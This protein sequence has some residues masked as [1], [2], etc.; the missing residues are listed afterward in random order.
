MP[1]SVLRNME[2]LAPAGDPDSLAAALDAGADA[3]YLG[4]R[5]LNARRR[6]R[7]FTAD[8]LRAAV[9]TAHARGRRIYLALN[10]DISQRELGEAARILELAR[11]CGVDAVL[12]RD[13][14][15][16]ALRPLLGDLEFHFS[17]QTCMTSSADVAAA[18]QLGAARAVL[19]REL[20]LDEIRAAARA[21]GTGVEV[22]VQG[23]L[24]FCIS[25]RCLL[26][27]WV[28]GR[29]GNRGMCTSPCRVPW[30]AGGVDAGTPLS[31]LDL[32]A[33]GRL[34]DLRRAGVVALKIEGR[35]KNA[36]WVAR[37][38]S[39]YR[40]A[41]DS[42]DAAALEA[43]AQVL[44]RYTGRRM[45]CDYLDGRRDRLT[46]LAAGRSAPDGS[47][48]EADS[49]PHETPGYDF[50]MAITDRA[51]EC[52]CEHGGRSV[53]WTLPRTRVIRR[54]RA[55][56]AGELL[57]RLGPV[58]GV[59]PRR[60]SASD[61]S[62]LLVPRA[63]NAI[64]DR[65]CAAVRQML[66]QD[67][68]PLRI[69]LPA[70]VAAALTAPEPHPANSLAL[71][72]PPDRARLDAS[73][74]EAFMRSV[75]AGRGGPRGI[76]VEGADA[77]SLARIRSLCRSCDLVVALPA[78]FFEDDIPAVRDLLEACSRAGAI[79]EINSFGG[80][81]LARRTRV[82]MEGGPGM[83]VLNALA[84]RKLAEMGMECVTLCIEAD[85][86][87]L[88]ELSACCPCPCSVAVFGRPAL[89][90]TRAR[91]DEA[92]LGRP[93][94]DRRGNRIVPRLERDLWVF[95]PA[96]PFDLRNCANDRIRAAHLVVDLVGSPDP[97]AEW[98]RAPGAGEK[99]LRFN[100][101]RRLQ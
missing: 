96:D 6:A 48:Q 77:A 62:Y 86:R 55:V 42:A 51:I 47:E 21:G 3:V 80:W 76:I 8:E 25:G 91:L 94:E 98:R 13:A 17:T 101:D 78:V 66:R 74:L 49:A 12:V 16:L 4:L 38:V 71:G 73:A 44:G 85:R 53:L 11:V 64:C 89:L 63:A 54:E 92:W 88:E 37:A 10:T 15:L 69:A 35:L 9:E 65:V 90:T 84:A 58:D 100:Y 82:R 27:S 18:G 26:S 22:F 19:A 67:E 30:N 99:R 72:G 83:G 40:R 39:L 7:N 1:E 45:T 79:V 2:L 68:P 95:R 29:S 32:C 97:A 46:G 75:G 87:Q 5:S 61:E 81:H 41:L 14:A 52:R 57:R 33:I 31:M 24:C 70:A 60:L 43:E 28:G 23:A 93:F 20:T 59:A 36:A 56:A 50:H 34:E